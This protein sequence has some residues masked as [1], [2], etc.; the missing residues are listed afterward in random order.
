M[1]EDKNKQNSN[2]KSTVHKIDP[3]NLLDYIPDSIVS[4]T[5]LKK[6]AGSVTLFSFDQGQGLS[7]HSA[8]AEAVVIVLEG[9]V[10]IRIERHEYELSKGE[11]IVMPANEPHSV[12]AIEKL[13]MLLVMIK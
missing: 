12:R 9:R 5:I 6:T 7:T 2:D 1:V 3:S 13:K 8:P 11:M 4:K 10:K